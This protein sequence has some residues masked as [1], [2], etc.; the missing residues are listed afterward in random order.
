MRERHVEGAVGRTLTGG[1]CKDPDEPR[2]SIAPAAAIA[3]EG[4]IN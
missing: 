2:E 1:A 4:I 3:K